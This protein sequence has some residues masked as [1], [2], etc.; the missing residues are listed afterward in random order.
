MLSKLIEFEKNKAKS[1]ID[2]THVKNLTSEL[3]KR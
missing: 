1:P 3:N 2:V